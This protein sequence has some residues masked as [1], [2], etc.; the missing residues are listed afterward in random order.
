[1]YG[2][3]LL[4]PRP[5]PKLEDRHL[6]AVHDCLLN[7]FAAT[8]HIWRPLVGKPEGR[9]PL[10]KPSR[11]WEDNIKMD[12]ERLEGGVDWF[13]LARIGAGGGLL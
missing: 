7:I 12:F 2:K 13:N 1:M 8:L 6:S 3:E 4:A 11:R 9:R 5:T 10:G